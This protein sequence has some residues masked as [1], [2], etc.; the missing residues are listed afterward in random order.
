MLAFPRRCA[1]VYWGDVHS[2]GHSWGEHESSLEAI[3]M[4]AQAAGVA[5]AGS[6]TPRQ[7]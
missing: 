1:V 5:R 3:A 2:H 6:G 7:K 4:A